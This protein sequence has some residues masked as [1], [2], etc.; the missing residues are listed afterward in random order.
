MA[1]ILERRKMTWTPVDLDQDNQMASARISSF[2]A[3]PILRFL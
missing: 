2:L 3:K 1:L